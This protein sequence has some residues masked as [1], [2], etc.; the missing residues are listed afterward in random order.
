MIFRSRRTTARG[1]RLDPGGH[2]GGDPLP[3]QRGHG[4]TGLGTR[5]AGLGPGLHGCRLPEASAE[6][7]VLNESG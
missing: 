3:Q 7:A 4:L 6:A 2:G 1:I 5:L